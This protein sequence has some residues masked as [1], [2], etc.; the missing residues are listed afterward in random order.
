MSFRF[1]YREGGDC[2]APVKEYP[3]AGS[4]TFTKGEAVNLALG[5]LGNGAP[6]GTAFVGI[7]N[8]TISSATTEG[9]PVEVILALEDV[10]FEVDYTGSLKTSLTNADIGTV[11]DLDGGDPKKI[12]LD[13]TTGGAWV[14]VG[15]DND[16][17]VAYVKLNAASRA[18]ILG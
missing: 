1:A 2:V 17:G 8:E 11:F 6:A 9:D 14:V 3:A 12:N 5:L 13:D 16:K 15:F 18:A 4:K 7:A 10:V